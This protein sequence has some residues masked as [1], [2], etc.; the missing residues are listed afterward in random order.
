MPTIYL[1]KVGKRVGRKRE[2]QRSLKL[3]ALPF[4]RSHSLNVSR[5]E[6]RGGKGKEVALGNTS[7]S[8][9]CPGQPDSRL[10]WLLLLT[11]VRRKHGRLH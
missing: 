4:E 6:A 10:P 9:L 7:L 5:G 1:S 2:T 11:D 8:P 3:Y